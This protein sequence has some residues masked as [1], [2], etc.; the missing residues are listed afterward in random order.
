MEGSGI[1]PIGERRG[2]GFWVIGN[3]SA[4]SDQH[5]LWFSRVKGKCWNPPKVGC[6]NM[7]PDI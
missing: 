7:V 3:S 5:G 6:L 1:E 2:V 4:K